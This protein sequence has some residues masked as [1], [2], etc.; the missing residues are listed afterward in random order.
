MNIV[1]AFHAYRFTHFSGVGER[2]GDP[3]ELSFVDKFEALVFGIK[4]PHPTHRQLPSVPY[5]TVRIDTGVSLEGWWID[6]PQAI[7]TAILF[8]GYSGEKSSLLERAEIFRSLGYRT[9]L[10][11]FSGSGGSGGNQTTIGFYE[12]DQ[13]AD[14]VA[15]VQSKGEKNILV[16]GTSM[17]AAA[18]MKA[19]AD[20]L[21]QVQALVLECPFATMLSTVQARFKLM[22]IPSFPMAN[23]LVFWGGFENRFDAFSH[24]PVEYAKAIQTPTLLIYGS[25]DNKVSRADTD[26]I[27][28]N[29]SGEKELVVIQ[30]AGHEDFL[31]HFRNEWVEPVRAF[32][33]NH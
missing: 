6:Q 19:V 32:A 14:A 22:N 30:G 7:G 20:Q 1:A 13:V 27:F 8:H 23:L 5:E 21:I 15:Y 4:H 9:L 25:E 28:A 11:D 10:I 3:K 26:S 18:V 2:T 17:G 12:A 29:L 24:N 33:S 16:F 31:D